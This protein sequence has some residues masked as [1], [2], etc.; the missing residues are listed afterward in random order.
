VRRDGPDLP[1]ELADP[2]DP[3]EPGELRAA[4][5]ADAEALGALHVAAWRAAYRGLMPERVIAARTLDE[6]V[7][8]WRERLAA[9][10]AG[11]ITW[12]AVAPGAPGALL[13]FC[14]TGPCRD[15]DVAPGAGEVYA[16]Y[17]EPARLG[18]GLG[19]RLLGHALDDLRARGRSE[20]VLWVLDGNARAERFYARA[21]LAPGR[22]EVKTLEGAPLPHTRWS[23]AL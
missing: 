4:R 15:G 8:G 11:T 17:V 9:P 3:D 2:D 16:L 22:R 13:G 23:R 14:S 19:R 21:G 20:V 5:P 10:A 7:R 6:R 18:R 12:V 1:D